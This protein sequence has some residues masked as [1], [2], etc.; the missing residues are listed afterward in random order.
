MQGLPDSSSIVRNKFCLFCLGPA[1]I[2][3]TTGLL[4]KGY[5]IILPLFIMNVGCFCLGLVWTVSSVYL[6]WKG[7]LVI[8]PLFIMH[9]GCVC[10]GSA[11]TVSIFHL[12]PEGL[13][14]ISSI[15]HNGFWHLFLWHD[16]LIRVRVSSLS[17]SIDASPHLGIDVSPC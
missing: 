10:L 2:V 9:F 16:M 14:G 1:W 15:I 11:W 3:S 6:L 7:Y 5:L 4:W 13:P 8:L 17:N 12:L